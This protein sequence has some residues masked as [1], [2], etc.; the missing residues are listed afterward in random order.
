MNQ[1]TTSGERGVT[2]VSPTNSRP[3]GENPARTLPK[4]GLRETPTDDNKIGRNEGVGVS[5]KSCK[6]PEIPILAVELPPSEDFH[7]L[8]IFSGSASGGANSS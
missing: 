7:F 2:R 6:S 1:G 5:T 4:F 8:I 3:G